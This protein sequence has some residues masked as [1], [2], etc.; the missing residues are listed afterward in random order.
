MSYF[1]LLVVIFGCVVM[2][3]FGLKDG[4]VFK[5]SCDFGG[6]CGLMCEIKNVSVKLNGFKGGG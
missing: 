1:L 6:W 2:F 3:V 4:Y 5:V